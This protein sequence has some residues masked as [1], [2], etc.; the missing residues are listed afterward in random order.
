[1]ESSGLAVAGLGG[2]MD[3]GWFRLLSP[4]VLPLLEAIEF[5][6]RHEVDDTLDEVVLAAEPHAGMPKAELDR[7]A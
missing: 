6:T 1:M 7:R 5:A 2:W 4:H 3:A